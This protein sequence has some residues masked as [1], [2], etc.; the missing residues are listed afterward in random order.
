MTDDEHKAARALCDAATPGPWHCYHHEDYGWRIDAEKV[1]IVHGAWNEA[2]G[3]LIAAARTLIPCLLDEIE[4]LRGLVA[5]AAPG[6][7]RDAVYGEA[8]K[9]DAPLAPPVPR[10]A[11]IPFEHTTLGRTTTPYRCNVPMCGESGLC[12]ECRKRGAR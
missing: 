7:W 11:S 10:D 8:P 4:R 1:G 6:P 3:D 9:A 12:D 5:A 2:D